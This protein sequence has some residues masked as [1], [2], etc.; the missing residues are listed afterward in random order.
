MLNEKPLVIRIHLDYPYKIAFSVLQLGSR[1]PNR[2]G[3]LRVRRQN[4]DTTKISRAVHA[5]K[6]F[7]GC[8]KPDALQPFKL[9][10]A[11]QGERRI[12]LGTVEI[13]GAFLGQLVKFITSCHQGAG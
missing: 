1:F 8:G 11:T 4:S 5:K 9:G 2:K 12:A 13:T 10:Q 7:L 6:L 3:T